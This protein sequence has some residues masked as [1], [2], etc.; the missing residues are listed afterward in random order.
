MFTYTNEMVVELF[1]HEFPQR[2]FL[3]GVQF[4]K[5]ILGSGGLDL[6]QSETI[7]QIRFV[8]LSR[9]F[10]GIRPGVVRRIHH[11]REK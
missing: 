9:S 5:P 1:Q 11:G 10:W 6:L 7:N 8:V 2:L 4:V 3:F